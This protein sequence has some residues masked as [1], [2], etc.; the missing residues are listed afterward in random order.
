MQDGVYEF[1]NWFDAESWH[2]LGRVI[3]GTIYPGMQMF[4]RHPAQQL[5]AVGCAL[6]L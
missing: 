4:A 5:L 1:I 2:P 3:G 6:Q